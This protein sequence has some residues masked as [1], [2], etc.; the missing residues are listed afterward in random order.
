M[1]RRMRQ[2]TQLSYERLSQ[3]IRPQL[4]DPSE[5]TPGHASVRLQDTDEIFQTRPSIALTKLFQCLSD[6]AATRV[7][8][9]HILDLGPARQ[10]ILELAARQPYTLHIADVVTGVSLSGS[11]PCEDINHVL[12]I[13][14]WRDLLPKRPN[15]GFL[16]VLCWDIFNYLSVK[17]IQSL[18]V[19]LSEICEYDARIHSISYTGECMPVQPLNFEL[20]TPATL[21]RRQA[22]N[23]TV[24]APRYGAGVIADSMTGFQIEHLY[25]HGSDAVE[26]LYQLQSQ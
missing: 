20:L 11:R 6:Q 21:Y 3:Y 13:N 24:T 23:G 22:H 15:G 19:Y 10:N 7:A 17:D 12:N 8:D 18:A 1:V 4:K 26:E 2:Y 9:V 5:S 25:Q 14:D 16:A